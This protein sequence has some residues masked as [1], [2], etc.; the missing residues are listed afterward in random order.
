LQEAIVIIVDIGHSV[1]QDTETIKS[2]FLENARECVSMILKRKVRCIVI[3]EILLWILTALKLRLKRR[4]GESVEA[5][6]QCAVAL[7]GHR[8]E[9]ARSLISTLWMVLDSM[10]FTNCNLRGG[11]SL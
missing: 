4:L 6:N 7:R 9:G 5:T 3:G 11:G 8:T 2:G 1:S 10:F